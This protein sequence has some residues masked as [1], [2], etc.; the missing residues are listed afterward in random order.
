MN[1]PSDVYVLDGLLRSLGGSYELGLVDDDE[2]AAGFPTALAA[3]DVALVVLTHVNYR[4]GRL[5]DL[6]STT[7]RIH[8]AGALA[9][10]DLCHSA[11]A[12]PIA[13]ERDGVDF[14]V[15]CT[16]KYLNGGPGAPGFLWVASRWL[17]RSVQPLSGWWGHRA[18]FEMSPEFDASADI[19]KFLTGAQPILSLS[20]AEVGLEIAERAPIEQVRAKSLALSDLFIDLVRQRLGAHPLTLLTPLEHAHR[21]SQVSIAHPDGYAVMSNLIACGVIGDYREPG[22]LRF[23]FTPLYLRYADVWDTVETL[24]DILDSGSWDAEHFRTRTT[25]T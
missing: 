22:V 14:A 4:T 20:L 8:E 3:G 5:F 21:G 17:E 6:R 1:F 19:G 9:L 24:R 10:W 18:P 7:A 12:L 11:G 2:V 16:Y 23:G 13:L 15:G 25:V